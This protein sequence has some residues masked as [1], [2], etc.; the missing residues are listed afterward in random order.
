MSPDRETL[1]YILILYSITLSSDYI[2][3]KRYVAVMSRIVETESFNK[4]L[5]KTMKMLEGEI[6]GKET[7]NDWLVNQL[8]SLYKNPEA[9]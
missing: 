5:R 6:C 3:L 1:S 2:E 9:I 4:I 7:C 8:F